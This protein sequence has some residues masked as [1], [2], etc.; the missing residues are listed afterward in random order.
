MLLYG[1][2]LINK[3]K[4][5]KLASKQRKEEENMGNVLR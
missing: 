5:I 3:K 1:K 2:K 4:A